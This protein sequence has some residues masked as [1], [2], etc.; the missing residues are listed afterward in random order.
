[1][2]VGL[3][4]ARLHPTIKQT[5]QKVGEVYK[6][7]GPAWHDDSNTMSKLIRAGASY[8]IGKSGILLTQHTIQQG[9][10]KA[11]IVT[12]QSGLEKLHGVRAPG[13]QARL[14]ECPDRRVCDFATEEA[15]CEDEV[16]LGQQTIDVVSQDEPLHRI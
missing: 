6:S 9:E 15:T 4:V 12:A 1:M 8:F 7:R 13:R 16:Q 11:G 5:Y 2:Q 10:G 3:L 14:I